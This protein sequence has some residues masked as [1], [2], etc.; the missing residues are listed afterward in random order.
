MKTTPEIEVLSQLAKGPVWDGNI[1]SKDAR[2]RL[3]KANL[4]VRAQG[5]N[6]L[7][8]SGL[9]NCVTLGLLKP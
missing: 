5:W 9:S 4:I 8:E 3:Y 1:V 2:D 6:A 7:S